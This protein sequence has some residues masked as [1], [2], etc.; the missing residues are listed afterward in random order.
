MRTVR[1]DVVGGIAITM[2]QFELDGNWEVE[3]IYNGK[4]LRLYECENET[5]AE[6]TFN[7]IQDTIEDC[8]K[9]IVLR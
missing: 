5:I 9:R 8:A 7:T 1:K 4:R 2:V 6:Y 3:T